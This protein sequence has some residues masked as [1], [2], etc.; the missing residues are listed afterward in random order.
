MR[1]IAYSA[2]LYARHYIDEQPLTSSQRELARAI[3]ARQMSPDGGPQEAA[4]EDLDTIYGQLDTACAVIESAK[5]LIRGENQGTVLPEPNWFYSRKENQ[6][7]VLSE[8]KLYL[9]H[10]TEIVEAAQQITDDPELLSTIRGCPT[11]SAAF[12]A[13]R[14]VVLAK[15]KENQQ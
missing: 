2:L 15:M 8:P 3:I 13:L 11:L 4:E 14:R 1:D 9:R 6:G 12:E 7:T 10:K 5:S